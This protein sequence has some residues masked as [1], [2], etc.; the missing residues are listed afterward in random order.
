VKNNSLLVL[1]N[2]ADAIQSL[3]EY[4]FFEKIISVVVEGGPKSLQHF[5]D[6]GL[7][8]EAHVYQGHTVFSQG[9]KAPV[10]DTLD[11]IFIENFPN[12][13]LTIYRNPQV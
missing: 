3:L 13:K 12:S 4:L 8:D 6:R 1:V 2:N 7:W 10:F 11:P 9:V 5:I